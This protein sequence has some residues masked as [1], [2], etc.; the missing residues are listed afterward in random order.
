MPEAGLGTPVDVSGNQLPQSP[1]KSY[2]IALNQDFNS[3]NGITTARLLIDIKS[4]REGMSL[5][6]IDQECQNISLLT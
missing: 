5:I 2:S 3:S 6:Q 1:E 4:E